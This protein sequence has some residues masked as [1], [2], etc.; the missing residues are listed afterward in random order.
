MAHTERDLETPRLW[1]RPM[2]PTD[3]E[4]LLAIFADPKVMA[5]FDTPPFDRAQ[6]QQWVEHNLAHQATHGY[7][8]FSVFLKANGL[9]IGDC[10][11][12]LM[13][14]DGRVVAELGYDFR[15]DYWNQ[16]YATEA[17]Q[18]VRDYAVVQLKLPHLISLIRLGNLPSRQV[19]EKIGMRCTAEITRYERRYWH[20]R[21]ERETEDE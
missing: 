20:Y 13:E 17:A 9:L 8:P 14:V 4:P 18:A 1:L 5:A 12:E 6:M 11:L 10:C 19:A 21:L 16:G 7:G 2:Q 3:T 15:S